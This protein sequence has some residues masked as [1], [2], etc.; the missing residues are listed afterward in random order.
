MWANTNKLGPKLN[1][2]DRLLVPFPEARQLL[3]GLG[4]TKTYELVNEGELV[5]VNIGRRGFITRKSIEAY[6]DR[7]SAATPPTPTLKAQCSCEKSSTTSHLAQ[8]VSSCSAL[9]AVAATA[10]PRKVAK[11]RGGVLLQDDIAAGLAGVR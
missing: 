4:N 6:V 3:G 11:T 10:A 1:T 5:K 7:L 9:P 8:G 2:D